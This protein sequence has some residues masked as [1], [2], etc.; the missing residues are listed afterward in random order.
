MGK[1]WENKQI[2]KLVKKQKEKIALLKTKVEKDYP[3]TENNGRVEPNTS[4]KRI[5]PEDPERPINS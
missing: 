4:T 3:A 5:N 1:D 2:D